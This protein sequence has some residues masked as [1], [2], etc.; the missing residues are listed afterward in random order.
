MISINHISRIYENGASKTYALRDINFEIEPNKVTIILGPSGSGKSTTLNILGGMDRPT[1]GEVFYN[2]RLISNDSDSALTA[3]RR[4]IVGFVFQFYNLVSNLTVRENIAIAAK[5]NGNRLLQVDE[6]IKKVGLEHRQNN[7]PDQ[8]SGGE[9]QRVAIARA[10]AK[11]PALLLCDEPTGAL[12]SQTSQKIFQLL[13]SARNKKTAVVIVTHDA[14]IAPIGD[15][16]VHI[17][18]GKVSKIIN[19]P[20]P[21]EV[22]EVN[23]S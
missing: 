23:W 10:L 4:K 14:E 1:S 21:L 9:M 8:L 17:K 20:H 6:L 13:K 16:I 18:D 7:F 15:R 11:E 5:L 22:S 12:D 19:N 3:Y 2:Q